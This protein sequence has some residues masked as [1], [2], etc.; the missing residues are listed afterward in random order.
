[1]QRV[2][3]NNL[4]QIREICKIYIYI[5]YEETDSKK[6]ILNRMRFHLYADYSDFEK[7]RKIGKFHEVSMCVV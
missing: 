5:S 7:I 2:Y 4:Y 1:M 3:K 6:G